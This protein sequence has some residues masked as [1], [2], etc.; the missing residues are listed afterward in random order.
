LTL[1]TLLWSRRLFSLFVALAPVSFLHGQSQPGGFTLQQVLSAPFTSDLVAAPAKNR[2]AWVSDS[3]GR[4]NLWV[5][6]PGANGWTAHQL[7]HY[8][9]DDGLGVNTPLWTADA[10]AIVYER[11]GSSD[12]EAKPAPNPAWLVKGVTQQIWVVSLAG[13]EPTLIGDGHLPAVSPDGKTVAFV[14]DREIWTAQLDAARLGAS[15]AKPQQLLV[16]RGDSSQL[17][18]SPDG[19]KLA[20]KSD[21]DDHSFIVVYNFLS[22][23]VMYLDP[24]TDQDQYPAWSPDSKRVAFVR[25][26]AKTDYFDAF[27]ERSGEPWSIHVADAETGEGRAIWRADEGQG[28]VFY[29]T[30]SDVQLMW[31]A[32]NRIVFPWERD[33]WLHLY[34]VA[35]DGGTSALLTPGEFEVDH[36]AESPKGDAIVFDSNQYGTDKAD[37]DRRH[38]WRIGFARD[39]APTA[40]RQL[41]SGPG[42]ETKPVVT[43]DDET[44]AVLRSDAKLPIRAAVI[45]TTGLVDLAPQAIPADFPAARL[46]TPRQVIFSAADGLTIHGQ[47]FVP[48]DAKP[49]QRLPALVFFHGGPKRQMLLGWHYSGYYANSYA[50]N[51][52]MAS[53][54]YIVL[55]VNYRSG[56]GYGLNFREALNFGTDGASEFNDALGAGLYLKSRSDVDPARI[57]CWGGSY[58]GYLTALAL[59]RASSLF[60]AGVDFHGVHNWLL[61]FPTFSPGLDPQKLANFERKAFES[62]PMASISTWRSPVLLIQG[63]DDRDVAFA[64][65]VQLA[66]ALRKQKVDFEELIFPDEIHAFLLHRDW[67]RAYAAEADFFDRKLKAA[68]R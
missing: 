28:S 65:T 16:T 30:E 19:K 10:E 60:A 44:V 68:A 58:G 5:A 26:P 18:W 21:R 37:I 8:A 36:V 49:G 47:L 32:G 13:G 59:A 48:P 22:R 52:Y 35:V 56:I 25:V 3:E 33:G 51:Q 40:P 9:E 41:T 61:E 39:G 31:L 34:S 24:S 7:T 45:G 50:M 42:I 1:K 15:D 6:E 57:G 55:S 62:S 67:L 63:D 14:R 43:S 11:G 66:E 46:V 2:I 29:S 23:A 4:H 54:G 64:E 17:A 20:F 53:R 27:P 12:D 38:V